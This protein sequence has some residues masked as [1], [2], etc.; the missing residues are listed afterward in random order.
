DG[1]GAAGA[2]A[3]I[4]NQRFAKM[5]FPNTDAIGQHIRLTEPNAAA[6]AAA[7]PWLTIVGVSPPVRQPSLPDPDPV[8]Y[9]P[10]RAAPP[11]S[12]TILVRTALEPAAIAP[13]L[14]DA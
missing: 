5:F 12:A 6:T 9:L 4:V 7:P 1:A 10:A 3:R 8:V 14:R 2:E 13:A 11:A